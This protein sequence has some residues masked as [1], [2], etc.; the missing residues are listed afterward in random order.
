MRQ[1]QPKLGCTACEGHDCTATFVCVSCGEKRRVCSSLIGGFN[2]EVQI[3]SVCY[4]GE[5][6]PPD[7]ME[8]F[9][10]LTKGMAV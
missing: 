7:I 9:R 3:C 6:V 2:A 1:L 5:R 8:I 10:K 4:K